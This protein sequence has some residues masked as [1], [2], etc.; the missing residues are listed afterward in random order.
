MGSFAVSCATLWA[1]PISH[2]TLGVD[3]GRV[4]N[5]ASSHPSGDDTSFLT[6]GEEAVLAT[7]AMTGAFDSL[8][9]LAELFDRRVWIVSKAGPRIQANTERWLAHHRFF[10]MTSIPPHQVRFVRR[11][12]DK[13]VV[14]AE[15]GITHFVDDRAEVLEALFG[16]VSHLY[17]FGP[18]THPGPTY[19]TSV[20]TWA[21]AEIQITQSL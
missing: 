19:S 3:F 4:I 15:L 5:D 9:R 13:A 14:C 12:A 21:D 2:Q 7:P 11:R 20:L 8:A 1:V 18:Q 16:T 10:A 6:G 17:L